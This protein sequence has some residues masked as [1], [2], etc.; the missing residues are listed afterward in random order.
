MAFADAIGK[1]RITRLSNTHQFGV[2]KTTHSESEQWVD[3]YWALPDSATHLKTGRR[4]GSGRRNA[5]AL[6][7]T[8]ALTWCLCD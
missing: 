2:G 7:L 3:E 1:R 8:L 5:L 6:A 4:W